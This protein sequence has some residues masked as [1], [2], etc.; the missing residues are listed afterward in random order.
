MDSEKPI[1]KNENGN[2]EAQKR[3]SDFIP[4]LS[5]ETSQEFTAGGLENWALWCLSLILREILE[6]SESNIDD[7]Q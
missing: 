1:E 3:A 7:K 5:S 4:N 6:N 2:A